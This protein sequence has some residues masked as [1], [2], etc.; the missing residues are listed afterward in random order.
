MIV[1]VVICMFLGMLLDDKLGTGYW[2]VILF[3]VG[4]LSGFNSVYKMA[5]KFFKDKSNNGNDGKD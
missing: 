5:V 4:A 1:P 3:F 2:T